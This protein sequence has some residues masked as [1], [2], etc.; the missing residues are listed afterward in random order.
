MESS[1]ETIPKHQSSQALAAESSSD[2]KSKKKLSKN[3]W[4]RQKA[5][6]KKQEQPEA[7]KTEDNNDTSSLAVPS[8]ATERVEK[9]NSGDENDIDSGRKIVQGTKLF[10]SDIDVALKNPNFAQ[11][12]EILDK[13]H[14]E[15]PSETQENTGGDIFYSDD[16]GNAGRGGN[17]SD[18]DEEADEESQLS[19]KKQKKLTKIPLA[20]LKSMAPKPEVVEWFDADAPDPMLVVQIKSQRGIVPVP[21]HWQF[22]REYLSTKRG[23]KKAPFTLPSFIRD[24]GIMEM[25]NSLKEDESTL[26]Q[27]ARERVQP[28]M[29]K[30]DIDYAKL[31]NAFFKFQTKPRLFR[32]GEV[33]YEGKENEVKYD[34]LRPGKLSSRLTEALNIPANSPPPWLINMQRFGPPPSY[35]GLKIPGLNAP[36][37]PGAQW[38]FQPGGYGRPPLDDDGNPLY[39]D[40]NG[41]T[42]TSERSSLGVPIEDTPW[43]QFFQDESE[44]EEEE[45]DE[46]EE[47][48]DDENA[49]NN[50]ENEGDGY[51]D[52]DTAALREKAGEAPEFELRKNVT[53]EPEKFEKPRAL[54]QVLK[55]K[56]SSSSGFMGNQKS[57]DFN[58]S[59]AEVS[60]A[61]NIN[62][63]PFSFLYILT[64]SFSLTQRNTKC[65]LTLTLWNNMAK[66]HRIK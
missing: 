26:R 66:L 35:P 4:R 28:K 44:D 27:K 3:Q 38:G 41:I 40:V 47:G 23:I 18:D 20:K 64:F 5:K 13:F 24:T 10:E 42:Q 51:V 50:L 2:S 45:S 36:I 58:S 53:K 65:Q 46:E 61:K 57:Y 11:Y 54:Y 8:L 29:G 33:Y 6:Q 17:K 19:K 1:N 30:L 62:L 22:K 12:K 48:D 60:V 7:T 59:N 15:E 9:S 49:D 52:G 34:H 56:A 55:E 16:E 63:I 37:P 43:G 39:G 21:E 25:R 32:I 31:Y 14:T